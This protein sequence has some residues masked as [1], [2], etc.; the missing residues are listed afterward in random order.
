MD[1]FFLFRPQKYLFKRLN[2][3]FWRK[4]ERRRSKTGW[5]TPLRC[6]FTVK[7]SVIRKPGLLRSSPRRRR[8]PRRGPKETPG[9]RRT[10][11]DRSRCPGWS[12]CP[13]VTRRG[14]GTAG[15]WRGAEVWGGWRG[16]RPSPRGG[17]SSP[18]LGRGRRRRGRA[19]T[20]VEH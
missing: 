2:L 3:C 4:K 8:P 11:P 7:R 19:W 10:P 9:Y 1:F 15:P 6:W 20:G 17:W 16:R 18:C 12:S 14:C 5:A 13:S